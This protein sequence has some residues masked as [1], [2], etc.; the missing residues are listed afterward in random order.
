MPGW[1]WAWPCWGKKAWPGT[2]GG[3]D[4]ELAVD[5]PGAGEGAPA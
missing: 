3:D 2:G 4:T 5:G 1:R